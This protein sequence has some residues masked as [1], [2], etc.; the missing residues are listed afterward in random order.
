VV[1]EQTGL[2]TRRDPAQFAAAI[3]T[4][5]ENEELAKRYGEQARAYVLEKWSWKKAVQQLEEHL[6]QVANRKA[7]E[8]DDE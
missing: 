1:H 2:L 6:L 3:L 4:F 7:W 5:L 8:M